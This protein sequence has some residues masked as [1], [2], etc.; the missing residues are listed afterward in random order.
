MILVFAALLLGATPFEPVAI[1]DMS[2]ERGMLTATVVNRHSSPITGLL[3]QASVHDGKQP[4][5]VFTR[6]LDVY[7]NAFHD[8]P[9]APGERV[10]IP[11]LTKELAS[12]WSTPAVFIAGAVF[13]DGTTFGSDSS[14]RIL[15]GRRVALQDEISRFRSQLVA[16]QGSPLVDVMSAVDD[17]AAQMKSAGMFL[18]QEELSIE[19]VRS[20]VAQWVRGAFEDAPA[21]CP[22]ACVGKRIDYVLRGL[23]IWSEE[24]Q[25]GSAEGARK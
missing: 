2:E 15:L 5:A 3:V 19:G 12:R 23:V 11:V 13:A 14:I 6:Y 20:Q 25:K 24:V 7:V 17:A 16:L 10:T 4:K 9:I 18:T 1:N 8:K 22:E 21:D